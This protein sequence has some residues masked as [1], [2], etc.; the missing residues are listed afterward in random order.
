MIADGNRMM[1]AKSTS[2]V[3]L[4]SGGKDAALALDALSQSDDHSVDVLLTTVLEEAERVRRHGVPLGLIEAQAEAI[5][6]P[7]RVVR[8]PPAASNATYEAALERALAPLR[9]EGIRTVATGDLHLSDIRAYREALL[10]RLG[11]EPHFPIWTDDT[12][13]LAESFID[14]GYRA[15]ISSV[16]TTQ[17]DSSFVG[18]WFDASLLADL[19]AGVDPC[20]E[21]GEFH[22]FVTDGPLFRHPVEVTVGE[23]TGEGRMRYATLHYN[24]G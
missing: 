2:T 11:A 14:R 4:W 23:A 3:L 6:V 17:L 12:S 8:V 18:R 22:T 19:P 5:G 20:G 21:N 13:A 15:V 16:D 7:L 10:E 1:R 9:A 24:D